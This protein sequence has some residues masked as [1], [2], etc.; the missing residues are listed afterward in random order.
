M[1]DNSAF[2]IGLRKIVRDSSIAGL[3]ELAYVVVAYAITYVISRFMGAEGL[4]VYAQASTIVMFCVLVSRLG[5]EGGMLRF[6]SHYLAQGEYGRLDGINRF[7][8][9]LVFLF[10]SVL[11]AV[12]FVL[13]R[14]IGLRLLD[15]PQ[16]VF[17]LRMFALTIPLSAMMGVKLTGIQAFQQIRHKVVIERLIIPITNLC[18]VAGLL[19]AG[20]QWYGVIAA[21]AISII[22]GTFLAF[23]AY[24]DLRGVIPWKNVRF[25]YQIKDWTKFCMPLLVGG[26]LAF[27]T[28][29]ISGLLVG[30]YR[31]AAEV[32]LYEVAFRITLLVELPLSVSNLVFAPMIG[33]MYT[34]GDHSR[35]NDTFRIV[36]KWVFSISL[37]MFVI[38]V[39]G[40]EA[41]LG[42]FG[43]EFLAAN[44]GLLILAGG[45]LINA[46]TGAVGWMLIMSGHSTVHMVNSAIAAFLTIG[47][48]LILI[49]QYGIVGAAIGV[50]LVNVFVNLVRLAEV[51]LLLKLHPYSLD[52]LKPIFS[53][54]LAGGIFFGVRRPFFDLP[55][56]SLFQAILI[57]AAISVLF[58]GFLLLFGINREEKKMLNVMLSGITDTAI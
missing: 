54:L 34:E 58:F 42:V 16:L 17:V 13:A 52:Y 4:G 26:V 11:A 22:V 49:P 21:N 51:F 18:L 29:R 25:T 44:L 43:S 41:I 9:T 40:G 35:L 38:I 2:L 37:L 5:F 50:S 27:V 20:Y 10:G 6:G 15:E 12:V 56:S 24:S 55:I 32:G 53:G 48:G 14:F 57:A 31:D 46:G 33:E 28:A 1:I 30:F 47:L 7:A 39:V 45:Q 36:T 3:G 19:A 8:V 23:R